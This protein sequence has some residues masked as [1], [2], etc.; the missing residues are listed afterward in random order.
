MT[1]S[2][3]Q[4]QDM[5]QCA[6]S[7]ENSVET[8]RNYF[9]FQQRFAVKSRRVY[10]QELSFQPNSAYKKESIHGFSVWI[11]QDVLEHKQKAKEMLK[12]LDW[13]LLRITRV[14]PPKPLS[15]LQKVRIWVEWEKQN[16]A[17]EFHASAEWL[18]HNGYNPDKAGCVEVSNTRNFVNWSRSDQPWIILHELAHAYHFLI[19]GNL[20]PGIEAAYQHAVDSRLYKSVDYI[21][22]G[23]RKAY[24]LTNAKEYFAELSEGYF[25][26]NDFYPFTR[27]QLKKYDP[28]GYQLMEKTWG[29][30]NNSSV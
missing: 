9:V 15:A 4:I 29:K 30:P 11:A 21:K 22:G 10:A 14:V 24:A 25:G 13:Q 7:H 12:E 2:A 19:L 8:G 27:T 28:V 23:K 16:G 1:N 3:W 17:A 6:K 20:Y 26:K 5:K 18:R